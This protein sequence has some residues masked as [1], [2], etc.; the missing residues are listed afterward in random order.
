[1]D[2]G[3]GAAPDV[4]SGINNCD[5]SHTLRLRSAVQHP[6]IAPLKFAFKSGGLSEASFPSGW[7]RYLYTHLQQEQRFEVDKARYY[8]AGLVCILKYLHDEYIVLPFLKI[9]N[10]LLARLATSVSAGWGL[11]WDSTLEEFQLV[12][13]FTSEKILTKNC[14]A[15]E[16]KRVIAQFFAYGMDTNVRILQFDHMPKDLKALL[17][18]YD[19]IVL[20]LLEWAVKHERLDLVNL[21][22][23]KGADANFT[24]YPRQGPA[25]GKAV[26]KKHAQIIDILTTKTNRV[27]CTRA[28]CLAI[29]QQDLSTVRALLARDVRCD[30]EE[31][32]IPLPPDPLAEWDNS[33]WSLPLAPE[34]EALELTPPLVRDAKLGN[35]AIVALLLEHGADPNASYHVL[36]GR[37]PPEQ[38]WDYQTHD[39]PLR[40][41]FS[42]GR[43]VYIAMEH[44]HFEVVKLLLDACADINMPHQFWP[45]P[46]SSFPRHACQPVPREVY[47]EV[48]SALKELVGRR[49]GFT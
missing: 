19:M 41:A 46:V 1:M 27:Y 17:D 29:E 38:R 4:V 18:S 44:D 7:W 28:L 26:R 39:L 16:C 23:D 49:V 43:V 10:I 30:I 11:V 25:L 37:S 33:Q 24:I 31:N 20:T 2:C 6:F 47:L 8:A 36:G 21:F 12:K 5:E 13:A 45:V 15:N 48:M 40:V 34:L 3:T 35:T 42:C 32:D 22:L 9:E 14:P